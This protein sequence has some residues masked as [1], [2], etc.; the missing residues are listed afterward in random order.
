MV[1]FALSTNH[2]RIW[3]NPE[4]LVSDREHHMTQSLKLMLTVTWNPSGFHVVITLPKGLKFNDP[5]WGG[6]A[7]QK[8]ATCLENE[9][10]D[11]K[12][13]YANIFILETAE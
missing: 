3:L 1:L 12:R 8:V 9:W 4:Q 6:V 11:S 2:E 5:T 10:G 7:L 13:A